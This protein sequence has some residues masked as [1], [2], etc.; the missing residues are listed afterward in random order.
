MVAWVNLYLCQISQLEEQNSRVRGVIAVMRQDMEKLQVTRVIF[1]K[2]DEMKILPLSS[3]STGS[4][5]QH[6]SRATGVVPL[7]LVHACLTMCLCF[8]VLNLGLV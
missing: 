3:V 6:F 7:S 4:S 8:S 1:L 5:R 2:H